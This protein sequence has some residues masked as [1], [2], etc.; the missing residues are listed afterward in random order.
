M[1]TSPVS[2]TST[3]VELGGIVGKWIVQLSLQVSVPEMTNTKDLLQRQNS[4]VMP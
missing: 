3:L 1:G 4:V 2:S